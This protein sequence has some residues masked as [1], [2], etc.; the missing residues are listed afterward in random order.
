M[1]CERLD[2]AFSF[3]A[4]TVRF[5]AARAY[6]A[7]NSALDRTSA[8]RVGATAVRPSRSERAPALARRTCLGQADHLDGPADAFPDRQV[9]SCGRLQH[10][11]HLGCVARGV[12]GRR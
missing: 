3:V 9:S 1:A 8:C 5:D 6:S 4:A 10:V 2:A 12:G 11:V 7:A